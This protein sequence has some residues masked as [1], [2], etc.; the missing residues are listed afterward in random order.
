MSN[1]HLA[2]VG[3]MG[4]GKSTIATRLGSKLGCKVFGEEFEENP[5]LKKYYKD[6]WTWALPT[7][8]WFAMKKAD[9]HY[10]ISNITENTIQDSPLA[11]TIYFAKAMHSAGWMSPSD[12]ELFRDVVQRL[13]EVV[14]KPTLHVYLK[15]SPEVIM[16]RIQRRSRSFEDTCN[17]EYIM[18]SYESLDTMVKDRS[19]YLDPVIMVNGDEDPDTVISE[20][21]E[22]LQ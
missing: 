10:V 15:T 16:E 5:Y 13:F 12:Y 7:E 6:P 9:Q 20:I 11:S 4:S 19:K 2:I 3:V 1:I 22:N 17:I 14:P 18:E 21:M 8:L